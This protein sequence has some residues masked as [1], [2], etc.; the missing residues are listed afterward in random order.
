[1]FVRVYETQYTPESDFFQGSV[2]SEDLESMMMISR[3]GLKSKTIVWVDAKQVAKG[4]VLCS[5]I[6]ADAGSVSLTGIEALA[7]IGSKAFFQM[8]VGLTLKG[9]L[10]PTVLSLLPKGIASDAVASNT[11]P[12]RQ[13]TIALE[14]EDCDAFPHINQIPIVG[15][16]NPYVDMTTFCRS[17]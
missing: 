17:P 7:H 14:S 5:D 15:Q 16:G 6:N 8:R 11:L 1:L 13:V 4:G 9:T 10:N 2:V 12:Q 3:Q